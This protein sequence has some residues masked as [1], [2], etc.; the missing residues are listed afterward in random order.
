MKHHITDYWMD[1]KHF[2]ESWIQINAFGM[3]LC[4]S[5]KRITI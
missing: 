2:A 3:R 1:G 5:K 4:F